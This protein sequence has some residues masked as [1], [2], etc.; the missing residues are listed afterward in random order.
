MVKVFGG[1]NGVTGLNFK[2]L[3]KDYLKFLPTGLLLTAATLAESRSA[4][5]CVMPQHS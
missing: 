3:S 2:S 1:F 5:P 4:L